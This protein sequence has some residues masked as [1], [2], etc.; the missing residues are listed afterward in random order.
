MEINWKRNTT[1]FLTGQ[2]MS[3][4][5]SMLVQ[6]AIMWH[7]TLETQSGSAMTL[8]VVV[9]VLP[10]FFMSP[11][12]GVWAD[13]FNRKLLINLA[14]GAIAFVSLVVA[15]ALMLGYNALWLLFVCAAFRA[16]G[17]GVHSPAIGSFI[18]QITPEEH[19][20]KINGINSSIQSF[21]MIVAPMAS[22]ALLTFVSLEALFF[23]DV[24]TAAIGI[25]IVLFGVK[26]PVLTKTD[27]T[28]NK[29]STKMKINYFHDLREGVRYIL[30][31]GF[32]WRM[33]L[34][35][36][37][38][39]IML[40]PA[41]FLT[42]L[43]VTR[44]FGADVWRLTAIEIA[45]SAGMM[46]GGLL[47]GFWGG[48][49]NRI[50]SMSLACALF[51]LLSIALGVLGDFRLYLA[52]MAIMGLTLPLYNTPSMVLFQTKVEPAY[53][54]RVFGVFGMVASLVMPAG[55]LIFGP[56][57]DVISIDWLLVGSGAVV[58]LLAI[59]FLTDKVMRRIGKQ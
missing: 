24:I 1:L 17:Q 31:N 29:S 8:Y 6:Y 51:G 52:A 23:I 30:K 4:F 56:L 41:A 35:A 2:A 10:T 58:M 21:A 28:E 36:T 40:S 47:I 3:L 27:P 13:R 45:F 38:F 39:H 22:G 26:I 54:G 33:M 11:F 5:G 53:M 49:K 46:I 43:Q 16:L 20:T 37:V 18:P 55:M 12:G 9:G 15:I 34:I 25:S 14:D 42:P 57:G 19:L 48:F 32:L 59:P 7:I 50:H 44:N